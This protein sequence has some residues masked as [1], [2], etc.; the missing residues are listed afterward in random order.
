MENDEIIRLK[1]FIEKNFKKRQFSEI[2]KILEKN[3]ERF[4]ENSNGIFINMCV[5]KNET[6]NDISN[7]V[8]FYVDNNNLLI[9]KEHEMLEQKQFIN[10]ENETQ[11]NTFTTVDISISS[12]VFKENETIKHDYIKYEE[13]EDEESILKNNFKK[14][15]KK[16]SGSKQKILKLLKDNSRLS[17]TCHKEL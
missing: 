1:E 6:L 4:S 14:P 10:E 13:E 16:F 5:L 8:K 9:E 2:K 7:F 12:I 3:N 15:K 17:V 11:D